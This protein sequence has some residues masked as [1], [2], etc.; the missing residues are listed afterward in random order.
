M[1]ATVTWTANTE[2]D[3]GGYKVYRS[4]LPD[5]HIPPFPPAPPTG[6]VFLVAAGTT[7]KV[8]LDLQDGIIHWFA[9]SSVDTSGNESALSEWVSK[10]PTTVRR[11]QPILVRSR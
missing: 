6:D 11:M 5:P 2:P 1:I 9:V 3:L 4:I 7:T 8:Y 10:S